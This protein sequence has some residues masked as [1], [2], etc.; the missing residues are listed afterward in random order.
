[1]DQANETEATGRVT[2]GDPPL[3]PPLRRERLLAGLTGEENSR[4]W[5]SPPP[6]PD[7]SPRLV[8]RTYELEEAVVVGIRRQATLLGVNANDLA[9][10][11]L[12]D[13]LAA[14]AAGT[15]EAEVGILPDDQLRGPRAAARH[16]TALRPGRAAGSGD[17]KES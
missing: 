15:L 11:L 3:A 7:E 2:P 4:R 16:I 6:P 8:K 12:R 13:G 14:L 1:M 10:A 17:G 5:P 9:N